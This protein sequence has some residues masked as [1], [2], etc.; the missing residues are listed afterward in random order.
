MAYLTRWHADIKP[1][2]ILNIQGKFKLAD[3][4]FAKFVVKSKAEALEVIMGG[5]MTFGKRLFTLSRFQIVHHLLICLKGAPECHHRRRGTYMPVTQAIDVWSLGCVFSVTA[6]WVT[7]GYQGLLQYAKLRQKAVK[8]TL[9]PSDLSQ[10]TQKT[11]KVDND[12]FH[13]GKTALSDVTSW[14][15]VLR[16]ALRKSDTITSRILDLVDEKMLLG[17]AQERIKAKDLCAELERITLASEAESRHDFPENVKGVLLEVDDTAPHKF[18]YPS[19]ETIVGIGPSGTNQQDRPTRKSILLDRPLMKTAH[20]SEYHK[21]MLN[22]S[23]NRT[24]K[25]DPV[26]ELPANNSA[27]LQPRYMAAHVSPPIAPHSTLDSIRELPAPSRTSTLQSLQLRNHRRSKSRVH[28]PQT[29]AQVQEEQKQHKSS[30]IER[31][32]DSRRK[33][34]FLTEFYDNRDIVSI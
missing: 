33:D 29:I 16:G 14:H 15:Q 4:G 19:S 32:F 13:D 18:E 28:V 27:L 24:L 17:T 11:G 12:Y 22:T 7:L 34:V 20:R 5:T 1:D 9:Q 31:T 23:K 26:P 8:G 6:T 21:S 2:N 25:A 10:T 30:L 3:P